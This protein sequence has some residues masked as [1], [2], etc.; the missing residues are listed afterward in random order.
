MTG[1]NIFVEG[2]T[3]KEFFTEVLNAHFE[4][5]KVNFIIL[6]GNHK[7]LHEHADRLKEGK[8]NL[9]VLDADQNSTIQVERALNSLIE[10][11][12]ESDRE[13]RYDCFFVKD[14]LEDLVRSISP[15]EKMGLWN[16]IDQ[17][18]ECNIALKLSNL[19][20]VNTKSKVYIYINAHD[21]PENSKQKFFSD[22]SI[23]DLNHN[24]LSD[25]IDFF[26]KNIL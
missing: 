25:I 22:G 11:E 2:R 14:N 12:K 23:W 6:N 16:C 21:V 8:L 3:D 17:Y 10:E 24:S 13:L 5:V 18:C 20:A 1:F 19:R 26:S 9:I 15:P 4:G 7:R